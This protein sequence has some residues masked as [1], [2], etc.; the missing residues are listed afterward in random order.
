VK[1]YY[2]A[3]NLLE[4]NIIS[5]LKALQKYLKSPINIIKPDNIEYK[6]QKLVE[7]LRINTIHT[8]ADLVDNFTRDKNFLRE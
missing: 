6:V 5:S 1:Y 8:K 2:V 3:R 7:A 4:G